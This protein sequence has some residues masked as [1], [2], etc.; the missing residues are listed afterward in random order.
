[1]VILLF[2]MPRMRVFFRGHSLSSI[3]AILILF[4]TCPRKVPTRSEVETRQTQ[5]DGGMIRRCRCRS[6]GIRRLGGYRYLCVYP[7]TQ[8]TLR[9]VPSNHDVEVEDETVNYN[10]DHCGDNMLLGLGADIGFPLHGS[11]ADRRWD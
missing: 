2:V 6:R 4:A 9:S 3:P 10:R 11:W 7:R 5:S 8:R 1:M